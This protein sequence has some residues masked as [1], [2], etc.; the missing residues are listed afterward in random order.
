MYVLCCHDFCYCVLSN[1]FIRS[2]SRCVKF[3]VKGGKSR[4]TLCKLIGE[5]LN[6][7]HAYTLLLALLPSLPPSLPLDIC[8]TPVYVHPHSKAVLM[9]A[10][11]EDTEFLARNAIMDYSL[12]TC[13]DDQTGELVVGII[14]EWKWRLGG[15]EG[16]G[17]VGWLGGGGG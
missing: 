6:Q 4:S 7:T 13:I 16:G 12:L 11:Q 17:G 1:R 15:R 3:D 9:R 10:I 5:I 8:Y 2:L 14:G